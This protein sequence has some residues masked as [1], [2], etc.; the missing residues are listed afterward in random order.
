M[1]L[2]SS[3]TVSLSIKTQSFVEVGNSNSSKQFNQASKKKEEVKATLKELKWLI[4]GG[5]SEE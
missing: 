5:K 2:I 4:L 1:K 3:S